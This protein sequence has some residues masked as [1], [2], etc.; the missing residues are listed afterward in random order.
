MAPALAAALLLAAAYPADAPAQRLYKHVDAKGKVTYTDRPAD[1]GHKAEK[2]RP[3]NVA[4]PEAVRQD[5]LQEQGRLREERAER[6][7][8]QERYVAQRRREQ[9]AAARERSVREADPYNPVQQP[10]RPRVRR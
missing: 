2:P 6:L 3:A 8:Q 7:A 10:A 4:S 9:E 1:A 5:Y